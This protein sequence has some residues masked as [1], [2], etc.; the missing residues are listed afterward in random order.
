MS[1]NTENQERLGFLKMQVTESIG[2]YK[3]HQELF[4]KWISVYGAVI[5]AISIYLFN[6]GLT[7]N[8]KRLIPVLTALGSLTVALGCVGMLD[9]I[10]RLETRVQQM[11]EEIGV[12]PSPFFGGKRLVLFMLIVLVGAFFL[13]LCILI[14]WESIFR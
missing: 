7:P 9:W 13:S 11:S 4:L 2:I 1:E 5:A 12:A 10:N 14:W 6:T 8:A 3:H